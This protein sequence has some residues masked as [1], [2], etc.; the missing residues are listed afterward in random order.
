MEN[1]RKIEV[2]LDAQTGEAARLW[3]LDLLESGESL[4]RVCSI[5]G[6]EDAGIITS[7]QRQYRQYGHYIEPGSRRKYTEADLVWLLGVLRYSEPRQYSLPYPMWTCDVVRELLEKQRG[8]RVS[9]QTTYY[10]IVRSLGLRPC[11]PMRR[12]RKHAGE[13]VHEWKRLYAFI[14]RRARR[15]HGH[16][17]Y[18]DVARMRSVMTDTGEKT[19]KKHG[20]VCSPFQLMFAYGAKGQ[21]YFRL[22]DGEVTAADF[23]DFIDRLL[24]ATPHGEKVFLAVDGYPFTRGTRADHERVEL[25]PLPTPNT[26]WREQLPI[27]RKVRFSPKLSEAQIERVKHLCRQGVKTVFVARDVGV[28]RRQVI[29]IRQTIGERGRGGPAR[30]ADIV[31]Q[32]SRGRHEVSAFIDEYLN[33]DGAAD[34]LGEYLDIDRVIAAYERMSAAIDRSGDSIKELGLNDAIA[35]VD[36]LIQGSVDLASCE[37]EAGCG[38]YF[39]KASGITRTHACPVCSN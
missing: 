5:M 31:L 13:Q 20:G 23:G 33:A 38:R 19:S 2:T 6:L 28:S 3:A 29:R 8:I 21:P 32:S 14:S 7:W 27:Q 4:E 30:R 36:S 25:F 1:N 12:V 39:V 35:L 17:Y 11:H 15:E 24:E 10:Q 9:A 18:F 26:N 16:I 34:G 37:A 22:I